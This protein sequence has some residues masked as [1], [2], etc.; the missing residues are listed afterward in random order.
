MENEQVEQGTIK[1]EK[2]INVQVS[3]RLLDLLQ[4]WVWWVSGLELDSC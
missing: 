4:V 3:L 2:M 1:M